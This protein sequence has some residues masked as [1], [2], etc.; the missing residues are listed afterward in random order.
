M[1]LFKFLTLRIVAIAS[2]IALSG[3]AN[4]FATDDYLTLG[5]KYQVVMGYP[6]LL[7]NAM[8]MR[9]LVLPMH[10]PK[11]TGKLFMTLFR[12][13]AGLMQPLMEK[14]RQLLTF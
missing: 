8:S 7:V 11:I 6:I 3:C 13:I 5:D 9:L 2:L 1:A 4:K 10:R 12:F 14:T